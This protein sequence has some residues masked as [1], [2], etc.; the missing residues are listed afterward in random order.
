VADWPLYGLPGVAMALFVAL[1]TVLFRHKPRVY[2]L[3]SAYMVKS[4]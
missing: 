2:R 1:V 4:P 3:D